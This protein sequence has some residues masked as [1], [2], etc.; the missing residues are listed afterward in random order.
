MF[1]LHGAYGYVFM[2]VMDTMLD[3]SVKILTVERKIV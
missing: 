3:L 1:R 2:A